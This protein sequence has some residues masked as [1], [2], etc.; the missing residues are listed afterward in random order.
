MGTRRVVTLRVVAITVCAVALGQTGCAT[1][2][3][4]DNPLTVRRAEVENPVLVSPGQP[5]AES[6]REVFEKVIEVLDDYFELQ[7]P[8]AYEGR[9]TTKP[10][11]A[12]G[13]EQFWKAGNPD[14][15]QRL[16]ATFQS[17]RQ[18]ATVEIRAGERGGYLV[19]VVVDK[20]LEDVPRPAHATVGNAVFQESPTVD[21]QLEVVTPETA[22]TRA[23]FK[24]GRDFAFEQEI[25]RRIRNCK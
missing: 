4:L 17:V 3:P 7:T 14:P 5:T 8:N 25:L 21:R 20:E 9:I 13:Y 15:R 22:S 19:Y 10:R 24:V 2:P 12:P 23:W 11:V 1:A 16:L 6:Y 18:V